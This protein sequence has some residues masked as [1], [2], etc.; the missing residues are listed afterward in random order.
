[1]FPGHFT[2][3]KAVDMPM[4]RE[5]K[6]AGPN[7]GKVHV[8][9]QASREREDSGFTTKLCSP[10]PRSSSMYRMIFGGIFLLMSAAI[11]F[12]PIMLGAQEDGA[13]FDS[14]GDSQTYL[15]IAAED[16][17]VVIVLGQLASQLAE[18]VR[19]KEFGAHMVKDHK[20]I[21]HE[22]EQLALGHSVPLPMKLSPEDK[23]KVD[24]LS[25]LSG[26]AFDHAYMNFSIQNHRDTLE[27]F[28][29]H[30]TTL[31]YPDLREY[32]TSTLPV[33]ESHME[34]AQKVQLSL[35]VNH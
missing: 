2:R 25:Q 3:V 23:Q 6:L 17:Q 35:E 11:G 31:K 27:Q 5:L 20:K 18:N 26:Q 29:H 10:Y 16:Q 12:F 7:L 24:E 33:L 30:V 21:R 1:M 15:A 13:K 28:R 32:F 9:Q 34:Q 22:A 4:T 19:V 14:K 8:L